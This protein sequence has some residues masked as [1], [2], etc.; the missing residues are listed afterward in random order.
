MLFTP[1][2]P[3]RRNYLQSST[4]FCK[5]CWTMLSNADSTAEH[6]ARLYVLHKS[7]DLTVLA[8]DKQKNKQTNKNRFLEMPLANFNLP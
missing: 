1:T 8:T 2:M 7:K 4:N 5:K 3:E 6:D